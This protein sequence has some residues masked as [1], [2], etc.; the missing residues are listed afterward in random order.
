LGNPPPETKRNKDEAL[1]NLGP[2]THFPNHI[3]HTTKSA[4]FCMT[5]K[6]GKGPAVEKE[7]DAMIRAVQ[8]KKRDQV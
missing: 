4:P 2:G 8:K 6:S 7:S 1:A 5:S 3:T